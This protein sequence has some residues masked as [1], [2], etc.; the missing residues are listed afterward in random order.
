[1]PHGYNQCV[2]VTPECPVV[3][4][5]YGYRPVLSANILLLVI[6]GL[7][8]IAQVV[9]GLKFRLRAFLAVTT[10]G[11]LLEALGY[12]GRIMMNSNPWSPSGF[13]LQIVCIILA[14]SFLAAGIYLTL[15]HVVIEFGPEYSRLKPKLY[16]WIF[17][18]CDAVSIITQA[19]GG[20]LASANEKNL[21]N[22]GNDLIIA[23]IAFQVATMFCCWILLVDFA[24]RVHKAKKGAFRSMGPGFV[25]YV[26]ATAISFLTI[27]I[28]CIYR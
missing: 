13:K 16:T 22:I 5:T 12:V 6:F 1:M 23:G 20:G 26:S 18:G 10:I 27:F 21:L 24:L 17:C 2:Q 25:F 28:R 9:L 11:C 4:T 19:A 3:A 8:T 7:T 15:K 14:P